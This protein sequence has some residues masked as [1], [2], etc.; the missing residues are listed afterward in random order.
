MKTTPL[1][2][3]IAAGILAALSV[4][5]QGVL[6]DP[7]F[8]ST[9]P[10]GQAYEVRGAGISPNAGQTGQLQATHAFSGQSLNG[11]KPDGATFSPNSVPEPDTLALLVMGGLA[12][13]ARRRRAKG[14]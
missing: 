5:G 4:Q 11:T 1:I 14:S 6:T 3:H 8:E 7:N 12:L 13:A 2:A 10:T 9:S